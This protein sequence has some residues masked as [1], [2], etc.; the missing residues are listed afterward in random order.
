MIQTPTAETALQ[1]AIMLRAGMPSRDAIAYFIP[2]PTW[3]AKAIDL[4][5]DQWMRSR[6]LAEAIVKLQGKPWQ[7]MSLDEMMDLVQKKT[8]TE[9]AYYLYANNVAELTGPDLAKA[10]G[11]RIA[12]EQ[13]LA[14]TAG[15]LDAL[16]QFWDDLQKGRISLS[17]QP[18]H[19]F[20][21]ALPVV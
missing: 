10:N 2:D 13:K 7:S 8:Y 1:L 18:Q 5:H 20:G 19:A 21:Q 14:G 6:P 9:M 11:F 15:K 12:I 17:P 4:F 3:D 16:T